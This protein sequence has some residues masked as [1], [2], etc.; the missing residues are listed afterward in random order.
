MVEPE[1]LTEQAQ[2]DERDRSVKA[3][4]HL[5]GKAGAR[6]SH[7]AYERP[8]RCLADTQSIDEPIGAA[9]GASPPFVTHVASQLAN[10]QAS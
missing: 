8:L 1:P 7:A 3:A 2:S 6:C 4:G 10:G 9:Q 5:E